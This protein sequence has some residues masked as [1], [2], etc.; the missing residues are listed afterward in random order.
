MKSIVHINPFYYLD[1]ALTISRH[2]FLLACGG[3]VIFTSIAFS[4]ALRHYLPA[5]SFTTILVKFKAALHFAA[6]T[7]YGCI[8][9]SCFVGTTQSKNIGFI[10]L[11]R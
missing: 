5:I 3:M 6:S 9:V 1:K 4:V 2:L 8:S 11:K 10:I 7:K